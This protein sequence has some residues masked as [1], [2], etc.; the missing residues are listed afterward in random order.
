MSSSQQRW[1]PTRFAPYSAAW[2]GQTHA[3]TSA[4]YK[5]L[6]PLLDLR[7]KDFISYVWELLHALVGRGVSG[8]Q[9]LVGTSGSF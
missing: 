7:N 4:M 5:M 8:A 6:R 9:G 3:S 2:G 1:A